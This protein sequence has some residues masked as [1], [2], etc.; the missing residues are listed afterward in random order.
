MMKIS[1]GQWGAFRISLSWLIVLIFIFPFTIFPQQNTQ[2]VDTL[3]I[4]KIGILADTTLEDLTGQIRL[5]S[6]Q[7]TVLDILP[8]IKPDY[9]NFTLVIDINDG[10]Q[11]AKSKEVNLN[12]VA[13][14]AQEMILGN[15][16]DLSDGQWE[17]FQSYKRWALAGKDGNQ[18][19]YFRVRYPDSTLSKIISDDIILSSTPP[20]VK[21]QVTPDSGIAGETMFLFDATE[22]SHKFDIFLRWDWDGDGQ[23]DTEWSQSKQET[24]QYRFGGGKQEVRL[25]VKDNSGWVISSNRAIVVYSRPYPDFSNTQDFE[26]PLKIT[27]DAS[28]SGDYEDGNNLQY[29]WDFYADSL[30]DSDWSME[31]TITHTFEPF[32]E[33]SVRIEAKDSQGL[34]NT[35]TS[36]VLN[37]FNNMVHVPAGYFI[38]GNNEFEIDERPAHEIYLDDFWIDKYPVTNRTYSYFLNEF[39][40]KYPERQPDIARF[41]DLSDKN[42]K[43]SYE[44]D[45]YIVMPEYINHPVVS[46]TWYGAD[47]FC[48][49]LGKRLP[50]EAEWEM[51]ARGTDQRIYAWGNTMDS[52][53]ANYWDSG[54]P[55]EDDPT[56][57]GFYNGQNYK[58]FQTNDS[59][60]FFGVYDMGGNVKEWVSDWYLRDYYSQSPEKNPQGPP[61]GEKKVVRG[62]GYLFH[63]DHLRVTFR[64]AIPPERS[65]SFIGFRCAKSVAK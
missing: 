13:P 42:C 43:I 21:F 33:I 37:N 36:K 2:I 48:R 52:S 47:V 49:F 1:K 51:A 15:K 4:K 9:S 19:V 25:E 59:P 30:W 18:S 3:T 50:T 62:G 27:F 5:I 7:D 20:V 61:F 28:G 64:Y 26:N 16:E 38:M 24:Y 55:F 40:S 6:R 34:T 56:P 45:K 31:K 46:V 57:V 14:R 8:R 39:V 29:R 35:F 60:S 65:A 12:L 54:D 41:I 53:R 17:P 32:D 10:Q 22:S 23:F 11:Y 44:I 63:P 58:G